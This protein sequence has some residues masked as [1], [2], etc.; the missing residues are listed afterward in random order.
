MTDLPAPIRREE[1]RQLGPLRRAAARRLKDVQNETATLTTFNDIDVTAIRGLKDRHA[2]AFERRAGHALGLTG[3][4]VT[5]CAQALGEFPDLNAVVAGDEVVH[6]SYMDI[7]VGI[8]TTAGEITPIIR[9]ADRLDHRAIEAL[10]ADYAKRAHDGTLSLAD[11]AGGTFTIRDMGGAGGLISNQLLSPGQSAILCLH[12]A[13]ERPMAIDGAIVI[14]TMMYAS[15]SYDHRLIDGAGAVSFLKTVKQRI[16][17]PTRL[18]I[19]V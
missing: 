16:E 17:D 1:R 10:L 6:R 12:R 15:L 7:A 14:R 9:D 3:F 19:G 4:F 8:D 18:I 13:E 11:L 2:Q 5:A